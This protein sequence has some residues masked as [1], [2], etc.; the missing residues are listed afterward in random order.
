LPLLAGTYRLTVGV[1][2]ESDES[3]PLDYHDK[4]Y[5]FSVIS[6]S[7]EQGLVRFDHDWQLDTDISKRHVS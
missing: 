7:D 6:S 3:I 2:D 5:S 4:R 1:F